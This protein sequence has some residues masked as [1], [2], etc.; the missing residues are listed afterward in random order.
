M[1]RR[2]ASLIGGNTGTATWLS[3]N[4]TL[5]SV[6]ILHCDDDGNSEI[7]EALLMYLCS[8]HGAVNRVGFHMPPMVSMKFANSCDV[9]PPSQG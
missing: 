3:I 5:Y 6:R 7:Y 2:L 9:I 4:M 8:K 1:R